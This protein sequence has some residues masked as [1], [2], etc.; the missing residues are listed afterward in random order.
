MRFWRTSFPGGVSY[1]FTH[2]CILATVYLILIACRCDPRAMA[3]SDVFFSFQHI[4]V[5]THFPFLSHCSFLPIACSHL[6]RITCKSVLFS[7]MFRHTGLCLLGR[8]RHAT[9]YTCHGS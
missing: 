9:D 1:A 5:Q 4:P 2:G 7:P 8:L 6:S 3:G